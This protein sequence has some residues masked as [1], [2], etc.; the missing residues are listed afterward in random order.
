MSC[1]TAS[2]DQRDPCS[3]AKPS[4][5][6]CLACRRKHLK[7]DGATPICGRCRKT[8]TECYYTPSRRGYRSSYK[9][10][11]RAQAQPTLP[12]ANGI[13]GSCLPRGFNL[14]RQTSAPETIQYDM[15]EALSPASIDRSDIISLDQPVTNRNNFSFTESSLLS[16]DA[17]LIDLCYAYFND[18]HPVSYIH[19][20]LSTFSV[21][22]L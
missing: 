14:D 4:A 17:Q 12:T 13:L 8:Q 15:P 11:S 3:L 19:L 20:S 1:S 7:C 16:I 2:N 18:A 9:P 21:V 5:L 6:A 10:Q 22:E